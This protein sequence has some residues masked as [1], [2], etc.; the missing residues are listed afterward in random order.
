MKNSIFYNLSSKVLLNIKG[1][2]IDNFI[3]RLNRNNIEILNINYISYNEINISVKKEDYNKIIDLKTI[4]EINIIDYEGIEKVKKNTL[5]NKYIIIFVLFFLI[6]LYILSNIIFSI[7]IVTTDSKMKEVLL[8][9]LNKE[10]I[11]KYSFKKSHI[12][13]QSIKKKILSKHKHDIEWIEIETIGTKYIVKFVPRIQNSEKEENKNKDIISKYDALIKDMSITK[14]EIIKDVGTYVKKGDLI[15]SGS[16]KLNEELKEIV[17][18]EGVVYGEVWYNVKVNYPYK[19]YS[20]KET[21]K[22]KK[23]FTIYFLNKKIELFNF[24]KYKT[25]KIRKKTILKNMLLP[26]FISKDTQIETKVI[27]TSYNER[28]LINKALEYSKIKVNETLDSDEYILKS[29]ILNKRKNDKSITL[30]IFF[31][32]LRNISTYKEIEEEKSDEKAKSI[33]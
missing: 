2:N 30:N 4:Y 16:V 9:N 26:I 29:I 31:S 1:K 15:V 33:E 20:E 8:E 25:K 7:N 23:I 22:R 18:A 6:V 3:K 11:K 24:N 19:Y 5:K 12:K 32:V 27:N 17:G 21:G 13:L 10:G 28:E 14:G